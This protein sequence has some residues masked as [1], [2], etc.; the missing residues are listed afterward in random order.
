MKVAPEIEVDIHSHTLASTHAY[1][2]IHDY[3][4]HAKKN[5]LRMFAITDHGPEME[6]APHEWHFQNSLIFPRVDNGIGILRG[7]EANIK[8][9][10]GEIDCGEKIR[11]SLDIILCG[12]H[13]QVFAPQ[14]KEINTEAMLNTIKSGHVHVIT[15]PGNPKFPIDPEVIVK[16]S[17][18]YNVALEVNNSSFMYSRKGSEKTCNII[19]ELAKKYDAPLSIGSDSHIGYSIGKVEKAVDIIKANNYP[20]DRVINRTVDSLFDYLAAKGK[21]LNDDFS[22]ILG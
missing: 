6:D 17:A 9:I 21:Y 11:D 8:T 14:S 18:E 7:I 22:E 20:M 4:Y 1:S 15:H 2:T 3:V 16:A 13:R 12:F 10:A 19:I 5:G